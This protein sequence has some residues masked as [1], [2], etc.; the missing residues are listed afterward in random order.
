[1]SLAPNK[2]I[3]VDGAKGL[4]EPGQGV[5]RTAFPQMQ[6]LPHSEEELHHMLGEKSP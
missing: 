6:L 5:G 4:L 3:Y 1:M 2:V